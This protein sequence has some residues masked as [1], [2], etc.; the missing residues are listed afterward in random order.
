MSLY[1]QWDEITKKQMSEDESKKF[2]EAYFLKE[3]EVYEHILKNKDFVIETTL[4]E[5][6]SKYNLESVL[7]IPFIDG[8][9]T[10]LKSQ[11][12]LELLDEETTIKLD[13]DIEKL[14]FNMLEAQAEWLYNLPE[15][16][17]N[18]SKDRREQITKEHKNSKTFTKETVIGRN[19]TCP[20][21]SGKKY[22]KCCGK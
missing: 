20:C 14:Y 9:N 15:W 17:D 19:D 2:W 12:E 6:A 4:K 1:K 10:S 13:I 8:I 18:L 7:V 16:E 5:F 3:K 11:I 21:G 22:K